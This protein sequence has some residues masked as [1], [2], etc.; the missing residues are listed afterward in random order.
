[1][2]PSDLLIYSITLDSPWVKMNTVYGLHPEI[3]TKNSIWIHIIIYYVLH[4]SLHHMLLHCCHV[5]CHIPRYCCWLELLQKYLPSLQR[6][7][8]HL[9]RG[10]DTNRWVLPS[11][12]DPVPPPLWVCYLMCLQ[13][14]SCQGHQFWNIRQHRPHAYRALED[15]QSLRTYFSGPRFHAMCTKGRVRHFC[16]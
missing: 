9:G 7:Y 14:Q 6:W 4:G 3:W 15:L 12:V 10:H 5:R 13:V 16:N 8:W 11:W 2:N 1:M